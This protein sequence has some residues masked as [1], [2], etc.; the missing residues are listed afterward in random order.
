[1]I[2]GS[3]PALAGK[4]SFVSRWILKVPVWVVFDNYD[5]ELDT[6]GVYVFA[7]LDTE[8]SGSRILADSAAGVS[9][10]RIKYHIWDLT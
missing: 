6:N 5:V 8:S 2:V 10:I 1:M 9:S 3:R 7:A 4:G